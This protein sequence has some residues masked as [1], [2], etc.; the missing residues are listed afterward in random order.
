MVPD[1]SRITAI[2][3][4]LDHPERTY[5]TVHVTGTNGK[6]TTARIV[7]ALACAHGLSTGTYTSP[8]LDSPR[9]RLALC[10]DPISEEEFGE[11]FA[12]LLP[13]LREVDAATPDPVTYFE[14]LT[15]LAFL[16]FADK[17]VQLGVFEVGMGGVW[18]ATNLIAGDVAV[19]TP[20][21]LD[22]PELGS[23]VG[24]IA[25]EK[26]G[27]IKAGKVA[28]SREQPPEALSVIRARTDEVGA[29]LL[30]EG[31]DFELTARA[32][33][34]G[35]QVIAVRTRRG[36]YSSLRL[37]LFGEH[38]ARNAAAAI[39]ALEELLDR[40]LSEDAVR[41]GLD[42]A[43]SP[44]RLEVVAR[45]PLVALDGAHNPAGAAALV[46]ALL[47]AF[48]WQRLWIVLAISANKDIDGVV[49]EL[50]RLNPSVLATRH[51]I[52]AR[53]AE[54]HDVAEACGRHGLDDVEQFD[55]VADALAAAAERAD[56]D[57]LILVTGSLY[58]VADARRA[59]GIHA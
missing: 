9:E 18:D 34:V 45:R 3:D 7:T 52:A 38:A 16:W 46:T 43:G 22:H 39:V 10:G 40:E 15:A 42:Q 8:H 48:A 29:K 55:M 20:I 51:S 6:T 33:G 24:E 41:A 50:A 56:E 31:E 49:A 25:V 21:S 12:R 1:L 19:L 44:G 23:T 30:L 53:S 26:A 28:V 27:I 35:G 59:L 57:D 17:P 47:E 54:P 11:E 37:P 58:T 2:A 32:P 14:A 13:Y 5:P 36:S 4:L